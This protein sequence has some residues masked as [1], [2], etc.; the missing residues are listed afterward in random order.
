MMP[1]SGHETAG[2]VGRS[3]QAEPRIVAEAASVLGPG[4]VAVSELPHSSRSGVTLGVWRVAVGDRTA[5]VKV[6]SDGYA[7]PAWRG[8]RD[9][10]QPWYWRRELHVYDRGVPV[11]YT[12]AGIRAPDLLEIVDRGDGTIALWLE[13]VH[14][15]AGADW[16][17]ADLADGAERL[18]RAQGP[19]LV[20]R[21]LPTESWWCRQFV[22]R[23]LR[24]FDP[25]V[26]YR[27]L[28]DDDA[29]AT[30]VIA[31][32]VDPALRPA[33][34]RLVAEQDDFLGWLESRPRT[35]AHLDVW[36]AN[37]F[38]DRDRVVL[39]D[40]AFCGFGAPGEDIGNLIVDS[41]FDLL[42]APARLA[43][44]EAAT[45]TAYLTGL[46]AAGWRGREDD[47]L[48][49]LS[50]T[51]VKYAWLLPH[52]LGQAVRG[53]HP[54]YGGRPVADQAE[55]YRARSAGLELLMDWADRARALASA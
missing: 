37:L 4:P 28:D 49:G 20:D 13:A 7:D 5:V 19:Y 2:E 38:H 41:V 3:T 50:C 40:W 21:P 46:R 22:G 16:S 9:P 42:Q 51:A 52:M 29:W 17:V 18:G 25:D 35:V 47:V 39:V 33:V 48:L 43:D 31:D 36:P 11:P 1:A 45:V 6:L 44:I 53:E 32:I 10:T 24:T 34:R 23:Y 14:G 12:D 27:L 55:L 30:P 8:S 15:I 54:G 26:D